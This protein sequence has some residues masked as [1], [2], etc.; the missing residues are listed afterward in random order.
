MNKLQTILKERFNIES[1]DVLPERTQRF[2]KEY[3]KI[4]SAKGVPY[5]D[6]KVDPPV[7][8]EV[9]QQKLKDLQS[10]I[11]EDAAVYFEKNKNAPPVQDAD[12]QNQKP[13]DNTNEP[14]QNTEEGEGEKKKEGGFFEGFFW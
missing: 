8:K 13:P 9:Y 11:I 2:Y 4:L 6:F 14:P 1:I 3:V 7:L 5:F 12:N 10:L